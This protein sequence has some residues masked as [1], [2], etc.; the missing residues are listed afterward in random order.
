MT[1]QS[2]ADAENER[3][4]YEKV[5]RLFGVSVVPFPMLS[6]LDAITVRDGVVSAVIETKT[7]RSTLA[8]MYETIVLDLEK[9]RWGQ[10]FAR[11]AQVKFY[12]IVQLIDAV[13]YMKI[14]AEDDLTGFE[15]KD[16]RLNMPRDQY[17]KDKVVHFP[18]SMFKVMP[19]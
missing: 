3:R 13:I 11:K 14:D 17:D 12:F 5:E 8:D 9:V 2:K 6:V 16:L 1:Y 10:R 7:R 15:I 19:E 4:V 18:T